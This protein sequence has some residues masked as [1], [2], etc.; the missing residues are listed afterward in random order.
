MPCSSLKLTEP[1]ARPPGVADLTF[2]HS[3]S[4]D[5]A[6]VTQLSSVKTRGFLARASGAARCR[7]QNRNLLFVLHMYSKLLI[8]LDR[9]DRMNTE[10]P[11]INQH[12]F[13][14]ETNA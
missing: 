8:C 2:G 12:W 9:N 7:I 11:F 4:C 3:L 1:H 13:S 6:R 10:M 14:V 5:S